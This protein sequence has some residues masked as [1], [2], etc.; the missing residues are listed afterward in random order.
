MIGKWKNDKPGYKLQ[1][2]RGS[3]KKKFKLKVIVPDEST[4]MKGIVMEERGGGW[5]MKKKLKYKG[6]E[7]K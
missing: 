5:K 4:E 1:I 2:K 6:D 3:Q 7:S